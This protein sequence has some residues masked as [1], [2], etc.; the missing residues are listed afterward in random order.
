[1][2]NIGRGWEGRRVVASVAPITSL[3]ADG[4][5]RI[6]EMPPPH[7]ATVTSSY[8]KSRNFLI[9]SP[10]ICIIINN[11]TRWH[12]HSALNFMNVDFTSFMTYNFPDNL[13]RFR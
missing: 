10:L 6:A 1:M 11:K 4:D 9:S 8:E 5:V 12:C 3:E 13:G 2:T 7:Q